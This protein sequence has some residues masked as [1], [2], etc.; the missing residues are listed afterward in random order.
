MSCV[1]YKVSVIVVEDVFEG[2]GRFVVCV[3]VVE[4]VNV[5]G[6]FGIGFDVIV[7]NFIDVIEI[8]FWIKMDI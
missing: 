5:I 6:Y 8:K 2:G 1:I 4:L 7:L 3:V